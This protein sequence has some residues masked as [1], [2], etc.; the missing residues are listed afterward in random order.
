MG[1]VIAFEE[2]T[3]IVV[4]GKLKKIQ[5]FTFVDMEMIPICITLWE[6]MTDIQG[7]VLMEA[8]NSR[9]AVV[10]K[11]LSFTKYNGIS[12]ASKNSSS[13]IINP[14]IEEAL[15]LKSWI[16]SKTDEEIQAMLVDQTVTQSKQRVDEGSEPI[17]TVAELQNITK[18]GDYWMRGFLQ[19][20]EE[21]QKLYYLA[22]SNCFSK[23][24]AHKEGISYECYNC[25]KEVT[26]VPRSLVVMSASDGTGMI[27]IAA[28]GSIADKILQTTAVNISRLSNLD[29]YYDLDTIISDFNEKV[30]LM[31]L[32]RSFGKQNEHQRKMLLV[33]Y[34]DDT[35]SS[36]SSQSGSNPSSIQPSEYSSFPISPL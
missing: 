28:I 7:P 5:R 4:D 2:P 15:N 10:A 12:L 33:G 13:F 27:K 16:E 23:I 34:F 22:C 25:N 8:M 11:R 32:R 29:Q 35:N 17:Y 30:F 18:P 9:A 1:A 14:P 19:I 31:L 6:E 21:E 26:A 24:S 36:T 20:H 3:N